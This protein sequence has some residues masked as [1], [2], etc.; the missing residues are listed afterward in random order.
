[1]S[2]CHDVILVPRA[3]FIDLITENAERLKDFTVSWMK[4]EWLHLLIHGGE[5][6]GELGSRVRIEKMKTQLV[7][8]MSS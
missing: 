5:L 1:M 6:G 3:S 4:M 2:R 7:I 8:G